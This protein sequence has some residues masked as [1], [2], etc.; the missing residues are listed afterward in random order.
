MWAHGGLNLHSSST[1]GLA[2]IFIPIYSVAAILAGWIIGLLIHFI[3]RV[4][5]IRVWAAVVA[6]VAAVGLGSGIS[7]AAVLVYC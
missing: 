3:I 1:A 2:L 5:R 7:L 6:V 4:E